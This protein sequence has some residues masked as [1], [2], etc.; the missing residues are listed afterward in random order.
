MKVSDAKKIL[1]GELVL[2]EEKG[3]IRVQNVK[4]KKEIEISIPRN[5]AVFVVRQLALKTVRE[6]EK[7]K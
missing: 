2:I 5:D 7:G 4:N 6:K 3:I 1:S